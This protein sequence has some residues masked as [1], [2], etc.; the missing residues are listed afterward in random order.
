MVS[1]TCTLYYCT[2]GD[3]AIVG[4]LRTFKIK[5]AIQH[6]KLHGIVLQEPEQLRHWEVEHDRRICFAANIERDEVPVDLVVRYICRRQGH[7]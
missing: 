7:T 3:A 2:V 6:G 4:S 5:T 1:L